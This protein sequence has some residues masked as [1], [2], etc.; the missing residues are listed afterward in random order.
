MEEKS[1]LMVGVGGQGTVLM[2]KILS[3]GLLDSGFDVKM[4]E[5]HGMAQRGGSV[6][7]QIRYGE[8]VYS[9][10]IGKASAD[11][12]VA[13]EKAEAIRYLDYLKEDGILIINDYAIY[14][15]PVLTG[16]ATYP[17]EVVEV[18]RDKVK[19][20]RVFNANMAAAELGNSKAQNMVLSF[21]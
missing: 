2:S 7:T 1:L 20:I 6:T 15:L 3:E 16:K 12:I 4:C 8:K 21:P 14:S 19:N 5:I 11:V 10:C 17:E 9:T 18:L 13:F